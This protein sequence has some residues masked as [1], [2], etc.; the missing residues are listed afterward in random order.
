MTSAATVTVVVPPQLSDVTTAATFAAG[1]RL[2][3]C[4]V[5]FAGHVMVG[6]VLSN[7]VI[8]CAHV[9]VFIHASVAVY[10]LV[11]VYLFAHV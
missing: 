10:T 6:A 5:I 2:A 3:H 11:I 7:T 1:T 9:A 4:T 8:V